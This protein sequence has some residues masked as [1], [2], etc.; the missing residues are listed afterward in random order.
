MS[1]KLQMLRDRLE[2]FKSHF[3]RYRGA[4]F[5]HRGFVTF[6]THN[7]AYEM[8]EILKKAFKSRSPGLVNS[9]LSVFKSK[10]VDIKKESATRIKFRNIVLT[11]IINPNRKSRQDEFTRM[12]RL[13]LGAPGSMFNKKVRVMKQQGG[14]NFDLNRGIAAEDINWSYVPEKRIETSQIVL[15]FAIILL[16][17]PGFM[18]A[19]S[20]RYYENTIDNMRGMDRGKSG[21]VVDQ[22]LFVS[23]LGLDQVAL[24]VIEK[25]L[26]TQS[27]LKSHQGVG[28]KFLATN[29]YF[30]FSGL[31]FLFLG[32]MSAARNKMSDIVIEKDRFSVT[33]QL[34]DSFYMTFIALIGS[35]MLS[36][37]LTPIFKHYYTEKG[38]KV[39]RDITY[40]LSFFCLA[41]YYV[42][43]FSPLD[44]NIIPI[45]CLTA[46]GFLLAEIIMYCLGIV[47][48]NRVS[49]SILGNYFIAMILGFLPITFASYMMLEGNPLGIK[50][51][52]LGLK[53][54][55]ILSA[56]LLFYIL[57]AFIFTVLYSNERLLKRVQSRIWTVNTGSGKPEEL[58]GSSYRSL[59]PIYSFQEKVKQ[60]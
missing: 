34:I 18:Y 24:Y 49:F 56:Y 57:L 26:P 47:E 15:L 10:K 46:L 48:P 39:R 5:Q 33:K 55:L 54:S 17:L 25:L 19:L 1:F 50:T 42:G 32:L 29:L 38:K 43:F 36:I 60:D 35:N 58:L 27:F 16:V 30:L 23:M 7:I 22:L 28:I 2:S 6:N 20:V 8:K 44:S 11:K 53:D 4:Y 13:L 14:P 41:V 51:L 45:M 31:F 3:Q 59:N 9:M 37:I 12:T 52:S 21:F 40:S